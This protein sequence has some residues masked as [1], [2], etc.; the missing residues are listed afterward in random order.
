MSKLSANEAKTKKR[1]KAL[2]EIFTGSRQFAYC[3]AE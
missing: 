1:V 2:K 3:H